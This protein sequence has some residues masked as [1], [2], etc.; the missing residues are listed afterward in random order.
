M[1]YKITTQEK[2]TSSYIV[3]ADYIEEAIEKLGTG[4]LGN[5]DLKPRIESLWDFEIIEVTRSDEP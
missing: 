1:K 5:P 3:E 2:T 4:A